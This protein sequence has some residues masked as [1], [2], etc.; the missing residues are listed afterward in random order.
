M[1]IA[2]TFDE[3]VKLD[4]NR[5]CTKYKDG[6]DAIVVR[7]NRKDDD[8]RQKTVQEY[9]KS[10]LKVHYKE[11]NELPSIQDI[12]N[13]AFFSKYV[14]LSH[15]NTIERE[16]AEQYEGSSSLYLNREST[17]VNQVVLMAM[18]SA[19]DTNATYIEKYR[20]DS[21]RLVLADTAYRDPLLENSK[22]RGR[23]AKMPPSQGHS[24]K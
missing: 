19:G 24:K 22:L 11:L 4:F 14:G 3:L 20:V 7:V 21:V 16:T 13:R 17:I 2:E 23:L 15:A 9:K 18:G 8:F 6:N 10:A 1:Q 5:L 12:Y